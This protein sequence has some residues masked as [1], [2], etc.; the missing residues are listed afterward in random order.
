MEFSLSFSRGTG[1][2]KEQTLQSAEE[3]Y[4][5]SFHFLIGMLVEG[6]CCL[7]L[8]SCDNDPSVSVS[9]SPTQPT[10]VPGVN[11]PQWGRTPVEGLR[12]E[13]SATLIKL[14]S[15]VSSMWGFICAVRQNS[16]SKLPRW[17]AH[18]PSTF[19]WTSLFYAFVCCRGL[20]WAWDFSS[21]PKVLKWW[22]MLVGI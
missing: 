19:V 16:F 11:R 12:W 18:V 10:L 20:V 5:P 17:L 2:N 1:N 21:S 8:C 7:R 9:R 3:D 22:V 6:Q 4:Y 15:S 14:S 13:P